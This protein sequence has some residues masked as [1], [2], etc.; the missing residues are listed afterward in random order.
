MI[1]REMRKLLYRMILHSKR[2]IKEEQILLSH[3]EL[4]YSE[5]RNRPPVTKGRKTA[6]KLTPKKK[7]LVFDIH[8]L[9]PTLP[10]HDI[11][12]A[13][14]LNQGRISETFAGKRK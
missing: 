1:K 9:D 2:R 8:K 4:L 3:L 11:A 7:Q 10:Q 5:M 6:E 14:I 12:K 13:T